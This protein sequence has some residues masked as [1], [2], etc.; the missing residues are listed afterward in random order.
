VRVVEVEGVGAT[1]PV[2]SRGVP[3]SLEAACLV[4]ST[5]RPTEVLAPSTR[6]ES[7]GGRGMLLGSP[8]GHSPDKRTCLL[9]RTM[10]T[11]RGEYRWDVQVE[12]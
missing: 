5:M 7:R 11:Y 6:V 10:G 1:L 12:V 2:P 3:G 4:G 9:Y 8:P